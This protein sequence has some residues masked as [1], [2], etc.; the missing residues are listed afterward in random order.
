ME[1]RT[2]N[3]TEAPARREL[4]LKRICL[5]PRQVVFKAWTDAEP[6]KR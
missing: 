5:A 3:V 4:V 2:N 1:H 6:L